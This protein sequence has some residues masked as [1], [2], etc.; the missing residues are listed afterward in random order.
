MQPL[1]FGSAT[2][3][4]FGLRHPAQ[5]VQRQTAVVIC[6]AWGPEYMRSYRG[7]RLLA[8]QLAA[9]GYE[10]LRFD[11]SGTGDSQGR[12]L[13]ARMEHW[14]ADIVSA[15]NELRELS[16][17]PRLALCG[18]RLGALLAQEAINQKLLRP[19]ALIAWDAPA[20]GAAFAE[21]M[22]AQN[23]AAD[24]EKNDLRQRGTQ[25]PPHQPFER[26]GHAWPS[27][28]DEAINSLDSL[29]DAANIHCIQSSD[30]PTRAPANARLIPTGEP[31]WWHDHRWRGTPWIPAAAITKVVAALSEVLP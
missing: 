19:Q 26:C 13:D 8:M 1:H 29:P 31:A 28:L 5:G 17:C 2:T 11:Y 27:L 24:S 10:T 20:N 4:L 7:M 25:L 12:G 16:G 22:K 6:A 9:A 14:L 18:L 30:H 15:S 23:D 21:L 3:P